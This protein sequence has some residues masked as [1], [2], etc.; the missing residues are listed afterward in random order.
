MPDY[1][2]SRE[3]V[4]GLYNINNINHTEGTGLPVPLREQIKAEATLPHE[5]HITCNGSVCTITFSAPLTSGQ[6]ITLNGLVA[7]QKVDN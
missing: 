1:I 4:N 3:L 6:E 2:Y 7:A 5:F